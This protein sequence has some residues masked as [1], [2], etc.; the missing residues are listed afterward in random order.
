MKVLADTIL[1]GTD[2]GKC[3]FHR[4]L[5]L[6]TTVTTEAD[7]VDHLHKADIAGDIAAVL[8]PKIKEL[9]AA[10]GAASQNLRNKFAGSV[11]LSYVGLETFF[12]GLEAVVGAPNP[13]VRG[14]AV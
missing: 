12:G 5:D 7:F 4:V 1:E 14:H 11:E 9:T 2:E 13:R 8:W 10:D 3:D 6:T